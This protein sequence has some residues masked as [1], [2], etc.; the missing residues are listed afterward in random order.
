MYGD[1]PMVV[2]PRF[3]WEMHNYQVSDALHAKWKYEQVASKGYCDACDSGFHTTEALACVGHTHTSDTIWAVHN[4]LP[5][6]KARVYL[7]SMQKWIACLMES[8]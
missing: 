6:D 1:T 8:L 7:E 2:E 5:K 4:A 3:E